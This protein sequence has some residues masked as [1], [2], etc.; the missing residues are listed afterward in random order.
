MKVWIYKGEVLPESRGL[1]IPRPV[2]E[3]PRPGGPE[4]ATFRDRRGERGARGGAARPRPPAGG[5][6]D[7]NAAMHAAQADGQSLE[8]ITDGAPSAAGNHPTGEHGGSVAHQ[9][10]ADPGHGVT[11]D[12][13]QVDPESQVT[14]DDAERPMAHAAPVHEA[15]APMAE[16]PAPQPDAPGATDGGHATEDTPPPPS[17]AAG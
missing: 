8:S 3:Q 1:E 13:S 16:A 9:T 7:T 10:Q 2:M 6:L 12:T 15:P 4:R 5:G 14:H 11:T 17:G